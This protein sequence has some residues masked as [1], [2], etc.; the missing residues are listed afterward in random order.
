MNPFTAKLTKLFEAVEPKFREETIGRYKAI[1]LGQYEGW[2][3]IMEGEEPKGDTWYA[4]QDRAAAMA[5]P[6]YVKPLRDLHAERHY[7]IPTWEQVRGYLRDGAYEV[8][9]QKA[10]SDAIHSVCS[11]KHHFISKQSKKLENACKLRDLRT[12]TKLEGSLSCNGV[13][14]GFLTVRFSGGDQFTLNM[15]MIVNHRYERGYTSF[16][17]YP[18]RFGAVV[19]GDWHPTDRISEKWMAENFTPKVSK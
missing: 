2:K 13:V 3:T 16:Y 18:A 10:E 8:D 9:F 7:M 5:C 11:A 14:T 6:Q 19:I 17:Q 1:A 12:L 4:R 15:S